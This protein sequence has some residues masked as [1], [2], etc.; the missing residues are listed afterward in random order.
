MKKIILIFG[1]FVILLLVPFV[2]A[3]KETNNWDKTKD[4]F[5]GMVGIKPNLQFDLDNHNIRG[6]K[7]E[8]TLKTSIENKEFDYE[9]KVLSKSA[10][11]ETW[12]EYYD[13]KICERQIITGYTKGNLLGNGSYEP[14]NPIY[15]TKEYD[16]SEWIRATKEEVR[17]KLNKDND[18]TKVKVR[19]GEWGKMPSENCVNIEDTTLQTCTQKVDIIIT[20]SG[21]K[22]IEYAQWEQNSGSWNG[23]HTNTEESGGKI[24]LS[25]IDATDRHYLM[26]DNAANNIIVDSSSNNAPL[27]RFKPYATPENSNIGNAVGLINEAQIFAGQGSDNFMASSDL[28]GITAGTTGSVA[29]WMNIPSNA[30]DFDDNY[31]IFSLTT[32][33]SATKSQFRIV[34]SFVSSNDRLELRFFED[35]PSQFVCYTAIG[36]FIGGWHHVVVSQ[37]TTSPIIYMDSLEKTTICDE[38][39]DVTAWFDDILIDATVKADTLV[40][41]DYIENGG[42]VTNNEL[43]G[44]IDDLR[45]YGFDLSQAQIDLLYNLGD[46]TEGSLSTVTDGYFT[47]S[48][49]GEGIEYNWDVLEQLGFSNVEVANSSD[50][51]T[52][53]NWFN[54]TNL[55]D[56]GID[57]Q[58][59]LKWRGHLRDSAVGEYV[60]ISYDIDP[61]NIVIS[62]PTNTTYSDI[63]DIEL[64]YTVGDPATIDTTWYALNYG[65]NTTITENITLTIINGS[66]TIELWAN[67][68]LGHENYTFIT[69]EVNTQPTVPTLLYPDNNSKIGNSSIVLGCN[70][71]IDLQSDT[72]Y[73][74]IYADTSNPPT[75]LVQNSSTNTEYNYTTE[76]NIY[77][78]CNA[79]DG[80]AVSGYTDPYYFQMNS[81]RIFNASMEYDATAT[82]GESKTF[83]INVTVNKWNT[84]DITANL[85]YNGTDH[86][87]TK[88]VLSN[89]VDI[90]EYRFTTTFNIPN[91]LADDTL[92]GYWNITLFL[93]DGTKEI[94]D[95]YSF[96]QTIE[97]SKLFNCPDG[98]TNSTQALAINFTAWLETNNTRMEIGQD[99]YSNETGFDMEF[100]MHIFKNDIGA[101]VTMSLDGTNLTEYDVCISPP[102]ETYNIIGTVEYSKEGFDAR[103]YYF[104]SATI[105][106]ITQNINLYLLEQVFANNI[107]ILIY[108]EDNVVVENAY[109]RVQR[110][111][112]S[113][114]NYFLVAMGRTNFDGVDNIYL[115]K[116]D[117]WYKFSVIVDGTTKYTD[118]RSRKI[119]DDLVVLYTEVTSLA[120]IME[121]FKTIEYTLTN[122]T[123][124]ITLAYNDVSGTS[125]KN[126][127]SV[128]AR[129][130]TYEG[131]VCRTCQES[132]SGTINCFI[133][134]IS[135]DIYAAYYSEIEA[136]KPIA[137]LHLRHQIIAIIT[138]GLTGL[139]GAFFI[140]MT[141]GLVGASMGKVSTTIVFTLV[142]VLF[143]M[144]LKLLWFGDQT[145]LIF[146]GLVILGGTII[147]IAKN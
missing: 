27:Y 131:F 116:N 32:N 10:N 85:T 60:N 31:F 124:Y 90:K 101:N 23:I 134:N 89:Q 36:G 21:R 72:I 92:T 30:T 119:I 6:N 64:N 132:T 59:Y 20:Y 56:I 127:L 91:I 96:S 57:N 55:T 28:T 68:T 25:S 137:L 84:D 15:D 13:E 75:T 54:V 69:F 41:G 142:G 50:N 136:G 128:I 46:G 77:Y 43:E 58:A 120:D 82:E 129:N 49:F 74:A 97:A 117:A 107:E 52:F 16:C 7:Q 78:R 35:G 44:S 118:E 88:L 19:R 33:N 95:S 71:S 121:R 2:S 109:I 144:V 87:T 86:V 61:P 1:I 73:Y 83:S 105:S 126:C 81:I 146:A 45:I 17:I 139:F 135:A 80:K 141:M 130:G 38:T 100:N 79:E 111:D 133:G 29:F 140:I 65:I 66:N 48:A 42:S 8:Y 147:V 51:S 143:S 114:D 14:I 125:R 3:S 104:Q 110:Y 76:G 11:I 106:N 4:F 108:D 123:D 40:L 122:T 5:K 103:N 26:N 98:V 9:V 112:I 99:N 18:L 102:E 47:S 138:Y 37:N 22:Y 113:N 94:N 70:G 34:A 63:G 67:D 145:W 24:I 62:Y 12:L 53:S 115:R 93:N 39:L